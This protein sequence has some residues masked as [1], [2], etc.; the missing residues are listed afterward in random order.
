M[1]TGFDQPL[2]ILPFDH[3]GSVQTKMFGRT[4]ALT[5]AQ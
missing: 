1:T 5:A 2:L 3:R 4:G